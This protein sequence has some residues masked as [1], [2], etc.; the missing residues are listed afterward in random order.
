MKNRWQECQAGTKEDSEDAAVV[1]QAGDDETRTE[2]VRVRRIE[3]V[4]L[5]DI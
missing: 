4:E 1:I 2:L 3:R 5:R